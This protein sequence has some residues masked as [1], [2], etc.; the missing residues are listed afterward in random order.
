M[1]QSAYLT[2][3]DYNAELE[4]PCNDLSDR[5]VLTKGEIEQG[6]TYAQEE[7]KALGAF[8]RRP[9]PE[10]YGIYPSYKEEK[11]IEQ[12]HK[13]PRAG[14]IVRDPALDDSKIQVDTTV[15]SH[16]FLL[17]DSTDQPP[18]KTLTEL[19]EQR[20][21]R[22]QVEADK[23]IA[24]TSKYFKQRHQKY[25][26]YQDR[27]IAQANLSSSE[28]REPMT[29]R[30]LM[31]AR[32]RELI[33]ETKQACD[34]KFTV[35]K[36]LDRPP[37]ELDN[38]SEVPFINPQDTTWKPYHNR[39]RLYEEV[40]KNSK[41]RLLYE[42]YREALARAPLCQASSEGD[43]LIP[44]PFQLADQPPGS[45]ESLARKERRAKSDSKLLPSI[46]REPFPESRRPEV[47]RPIHS[48]FS[49]MRAQELSQKSFL[50]SV[51][52]TE[53]PEDYA[54]MYSSFTK[55]NYY[56]EPMLPQIR[57]NAKPPATNVINQ[58]RGRHIVVLQESTGQL[59]ATPENIG[60]AR[61]LTA[62][63]VLFE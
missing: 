39:G 20:A 50:E 37:W 33:E 48:V 58:R 46:V 34:H 44:V 28:G 43:V 62:P 3:S 32:R 56:R 30:A 53:T 51:K 60:T 55:D 23:T 27:I 45:I 10:Y 18:V 38:A 24:E 42:N 11:L 21:K 22:Y 16:D 49:K 6:V 36:D 1:H 31:L 13:V 35:Q 52:I 19:K 59:S 29:Q 57:N 54:P 8:S 15:K 25:T 5:I 40:L 2:R 14:V 41:T 9:A 63:P 17:P 7:R 61:L 12:A 26:Q 4:A 47:Y